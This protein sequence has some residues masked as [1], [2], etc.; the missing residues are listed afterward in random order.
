MKEPILIDSAELF[1]D[2]KVLQILH[3]RQ[4]YTLRITRENKLILTK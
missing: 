1:G 2:A 3:N 4:V